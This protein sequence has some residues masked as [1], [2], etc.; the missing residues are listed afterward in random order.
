MS[1]KESASFLDRDSSFMN[2]S[3]ILCR[4]QNVFGTALSQMRAFVRMALVCTLP[5][6]M[7]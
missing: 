2:P 6:S 5:G 1:E 7:G 3:S 4:S